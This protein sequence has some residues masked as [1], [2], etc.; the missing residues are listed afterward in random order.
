MNPTLNS[1][2]DKSYSNVSS[3]QDS[4][5]KALNLFNNDLNLVDA[6]RVYNPT[7]KDYTFFSSRYK[8]FRIDYIFVSSGLLASVHYTVEFLPRHLSD[9]NPIRSTFN[10]GKIKN[11]ASRWKFNCTLL[12][13]ILNTSK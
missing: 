2:I 10:Y 11:N 3:T 8:T 9:H 5:S 12:K 6:W 1:N 4:A 7:T 13:K